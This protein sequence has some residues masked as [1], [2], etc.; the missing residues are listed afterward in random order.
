MHED[1]TTHETMHLLVQWGQGFSQSQINNM[2]RDWIEGLAAWGACVAT[3]TGNII[4][5]PCGWNRPYLITLEQAMHINSLTNAQ[6]KSIGA[7]NA[8]WEQVTIGCYL[9]DY[10][11]ARPEGVAGIVRVFALVGTGNSRADAIQSV[12]QISEDELYH[13]FFKNLGW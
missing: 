13:T 2:G 4:P 1:G 6:A 12:Y 7:P 10:L 9:M 11:S 5:P 8:D 3:V